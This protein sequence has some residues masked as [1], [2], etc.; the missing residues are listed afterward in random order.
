M[1]P[2]YPSSFPFEHTLPLPALECEHETQ[3]AQQYKAAERYLKRLDYQLSKLEEWKSQ[4]ELY[5]KMRD[6]L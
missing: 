1:F 3:Y 5:R 4:Y 2:H 6:G